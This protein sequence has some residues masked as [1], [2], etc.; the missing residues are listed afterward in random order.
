M[1]EQD[2]N[3]GLREKSAPKRPRHED[4]ADTQ[5]ARQE[6][7]QALVSYFESGIKAPEEHGRLG[8]ELEHMLVHD[9]L[10]YVSYSEKHG[11]QWVLEQLK[12]TYPDEV[13]DAEGDLLGLNR[14]GEA[15]TIEPSAQLEL[16]AGPYECL[17]VAASHFDAFEKLVAGIV[18]PVGEHVLATGYRPRGIARELEIIP[19]T[20]YAFMNTYLSAKSAYAPRMM[21]GT[22]ATQISIDYYSVEDCLRKIR[23]ANT[24]V[25]ILSLIADNTPVFENEK[26]PHKLMRT[27]IWRYCDEDRCGIVPGSCARDFQLAEYAQYILDTPA[28]LYPDGTGGWAYSEKTFGEIYASK[29]MNEAEVMHAISMLFNDVRLKTYIEIRPADSMPI[30]Y[31]IA[32]AGIIKG[33]FY[34]DENLSYLEDVFAGVDEEAIEDAKTSC[35][36]LGYDAY[37]YGRPVADLADMLI[38]LAKKGLS[39]KE[40]PYLEPLAK[41]VSER[42]TLAD[43]GAIFDTRTGEKLET[44]FESGERPAQHEDGCDNYEKMVRVAYKGYFDDGSVFIDQIDEPIEFPCVD[45]WMPPA[46]I[47]TVR[48]MKVGETR[49]V[50]V[51]Q[52]EAYEEHSED[53][54][55]RVPLEKIPADTHLV[56]GEM[57]NLE[58]DDGQTYPARLIQITDDEAVFD[59]NADAIAKALNFEITLLDVSD[60][61][62]RIR[63]AQ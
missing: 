46:F 38:T 26:R 50:R 17:S 34:R 30:P 15:I 42:R 36:N 47:E 58:Q 29:P 54:I 60:F 9:D 1:T 16:S 10:S 43:A 48:T 37:V 41:L 22:A 4:F 6:N 24:L 7:I 18:E 63:T 49:Q 39:E 3:Q 52:N 44:L 31:A 45:G 25:P 33:I 19:K 27:E 56:V 53:R 62:P 57:L 51:N 11:V 14:P 32:Y 21:R 28:I 20:R 59:M 12:S 61:G 23:I 5:P 2:S 13:R 35:M 55:I 8:I 40:Q